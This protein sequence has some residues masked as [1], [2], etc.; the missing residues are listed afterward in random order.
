MTIRLMDG[1]PDPEYSG[2]AHVATRSPEPPKTD[3]GS[4]L[5]SADEFAPEKVEP[6]SEITGSLR[7]A[8]YNIRI[9]GRAVPV[10][11]HVKQRAM[12]EEISI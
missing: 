10:F 7:T 6:H 2:R 11:F 1:E 3:S 9:A 4:S 5:E 12:G 8:T